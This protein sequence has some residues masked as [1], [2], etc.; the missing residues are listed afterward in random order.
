MNNRNPSEVLYHKFIIQGFVSCQDWGHPSSLKT[1]TTL[2]GSE[3][4]YNYYDYMD[5]F[6]KVLFS[7]NKD[8]DYSWFMMFDKKISD[9]IPSWFIKWWEMFESIPQIFPEPIQDALRYFS[10]RFQVT[11]HT[12]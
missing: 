6:E 11:S 8:F 10:S 4:Q 5:A 7:Q 2:K 12:S 9:Q 3:A 1:L